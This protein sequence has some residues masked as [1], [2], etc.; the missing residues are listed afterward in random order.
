[1]DNDSII[2][3]SSYTLIK[4]KKEWMAW[5]EM[6]FLKRYDICKFGEKITCNKNDN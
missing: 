2:L 4:K 1:M 3:Y 5:K 6:N